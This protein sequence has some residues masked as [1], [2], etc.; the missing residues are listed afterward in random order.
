VRE[1]GGEHFETWE[2]MLYVMNVYG[3]ASTL[4]HLEDVY[5]LNGYRIKGIVFE[6]DPKVRDETR[7]SI[8]ERYPDLKRR[9]EERG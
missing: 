5:G 3:E 6:F 1:T 8:D 9:R 4:R 7:R 2:E